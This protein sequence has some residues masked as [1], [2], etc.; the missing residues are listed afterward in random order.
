ME[1]EMEMEMKSMLCNVHI[2]KLI[3]KFKSMTSPNITANV[4]HVH[5]I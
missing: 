1:M 2:K 5:D 3:T 4:N